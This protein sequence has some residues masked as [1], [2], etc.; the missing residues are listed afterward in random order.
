[1]SSASRRKKSQ[2][3]SKDGL[4]VGASGRGKPPLSPNCYAQPHYGCEQSLN[5]PP[6]NTK[7]NDYDELR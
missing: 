2:K 3:N 5:V 7:E 4:S 1:M 6:N